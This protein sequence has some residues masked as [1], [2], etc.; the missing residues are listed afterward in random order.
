MRLQAGVSEKKRHMGAFAM[1]SVQD[2]GC[3]M[4]R[5]TVARIF[6]PFFTTKEDRDNAGLGLSTVYNIVQQHHGFIDVKSNPGKGTVFS[7]YFPVYS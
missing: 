4:S 2:N 5:E 3:G 7:V 1:L 6:E